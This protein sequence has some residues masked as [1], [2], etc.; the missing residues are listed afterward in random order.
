MLGFGVAG[1][2]LKTYGFQVG[3]V[4]LGPLLDTNHHRAMISAS[5]DPL[6]F[7]SELFTSPVSLVLVLL[8]TLT[9]MSQTRY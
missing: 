7:A 8:L 5:N 1:Y 4:I 6:Q 9:V 3:P 2:F